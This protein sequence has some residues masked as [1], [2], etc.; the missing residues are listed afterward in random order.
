MNNE[1]SFRLKREPMNKHEKIKLGA[2][3]FIMACTLFA[4]AAI[5]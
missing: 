4:C 5:L 2:V 3:L 1:K